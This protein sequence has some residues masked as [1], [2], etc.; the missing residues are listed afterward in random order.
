LGSA[1]LALAA[2]QDP[3]AVQTRDTHQNLLIAADPYLSAERSKTP[4][5]KKTPYEGGILA[6]DVHFRNDNDSPIRLDLDT[7]RLVVSRPGEQ[8]QRLAPLTPEDAADRLVLEGHPNPRTPRH[9]F[10]FPGSG[11]QSGKGKA[12]DEMDTTLRSVALV[13]DV[14]PPHGTIHG[15]LYFDMNH[16]YEAIRYSHLYIPDLTFM[17]DKRPLLFFE[18]DFSNVSIN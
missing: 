17:T 11:S 15:F 6:I 8:R 12:W 5:G 2:Q 4:Y 10:P 3:F 7:V 18:I 14:V 9:P 13:A 1:A 16:E